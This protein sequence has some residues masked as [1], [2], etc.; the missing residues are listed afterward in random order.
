MSS[1]ETPFRCLLPN[2]LPQC[3]RRHTDSTQT[4]RAVK[5][6]L[7]NQVKSV[8]SLYTEGLKIL[9]PEHDPHSGPVCLQ[10]SVLL[11]ALLE[12]A[13]AIKNIAIKHIPSGKIC[14]VHTHVFLIYETEQKEEILIDPSYKQFFNGRTDLEHQVG[15]IPPVF[16]GKR[17]DLY[18]L[19][20]ELL[21][22]DQ[23]TLIE[24][25]LT[26]F[27]HNTQPDSGPQ[28]IKKNYQGGENLTLGKSLSKVFDRLKE[29]EDPANI[30]DYCYEML[31]IAPNYSTTG[32][33]PTA[34]SGIFG[35]KEDLVRF[36]TWAKDSLKK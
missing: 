5:S 30:A 22:P 35:E 19:I 2:Y 17:E 28:V 29:G 9:F 24:K 27:G 36:L 18:E 21:G 33:T 31:T 25:C 7:F 6:E 15:L 4:F 23:R 26:L 34:L 20:N 1:R 8:L 3:G 11:A 32:T 12:N 13:G 16:I 10:G 14:C